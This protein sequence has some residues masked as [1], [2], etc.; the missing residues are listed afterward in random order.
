MPHVIEPV[1]I[2]PFVQKIVGKL[3]ILSIAAFHVMADEKMI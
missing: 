1:R 3:N 2:G